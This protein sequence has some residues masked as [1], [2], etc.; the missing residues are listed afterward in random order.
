[1]SQGV[2]QCHKGGN[3]QQFFDRKNGI[4]PKRHSFSKTETCPTTRPNMD[5]ACNRENH[6]KKNKMMIAMQRLY[7]TIQQ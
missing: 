3:S 4:V 6:T 5:C 2:T 1:M 7:V